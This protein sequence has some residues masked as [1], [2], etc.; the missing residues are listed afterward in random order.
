MLLS[1]SKLIESELKPL[2]D[3]VEKYDIELRFVGGVTRDYLLFNT[4]VK[5]I[6]IEISFHNKLLFEE[7]WS[8]LK[9]EITKVYKINEKSYNVFCFNINEYEIEF[10]PIRKEIFNNSHDHRN[11]TADY[12]NYL[13]ADD[14]FKRRDFTINAISL[15]YYKGNYKVVDPFAGIKAIEERTLFFCDEED[16][17]KDPVRFLRAFRF[18]A[19]Y[20]LKLSLALNKAL[21][22]IELTSL[23]PYYF[24]YELKKSQDLKFFFNASM[25][26]MNFHV[27]IKSK[28]VLQAKEKTFYQ[29]NKLADILLSNQQRLD[30]IIPLT[31]SCNKNLISQFNYSESL[32]DF[33]DQF[34]KFL[35]SVD[36]LLV[37]VL[38]I[39]SFNDALNDY[40]FNH[41]FAYFNSF[42][43]FEWG[44]EL[45]K[46]FNYDNY[47][48]VLD[49][50]N[51]KFDASNLSL[52]K[53]LIN[54]F[55]F[56]HFIQ[57]KLC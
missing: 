8:H 29:F 44:I 27:W 6:D 17:K 36:N 30:Y 20:N 43:R 21:E 51:F 48:L 15:V 16:F 4:L 10:S 55:K 28:G 42:I 39:D 49:F 26:K 33:C 57:D 50:K 18:Q 46:V 23:S 19:K 52:D 5:D 2:I 34:E 31:F 54:K 25:S 3:I 45:I 38:S 41:L 22:E 35:T 11:F 56:F 13:S 47:K 40:A 12:F 24:F 37:E 53:S 9:S 14:S 32:Y 1:L 7:N